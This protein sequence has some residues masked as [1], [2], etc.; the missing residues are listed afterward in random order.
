MT[1]CNVVSCCCQVASDESETEDDEEEDEVKQPK[2]AKKEARVSVTMKLVKT[3]SGLLR[4]SCHSILISKV[5]SMYTRAG[6]N[7]TPELEFLAKGPVTHTRR[8]EN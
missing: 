5:W 8:I 2:K 4:V 3:W 6:V 7:S 1:L